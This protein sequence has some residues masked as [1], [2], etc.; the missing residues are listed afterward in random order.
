MYIYQQQAI[1]NAQRLTYARFMDGDGGIIF[2]RD[3]DFVSARTFE[4]EYK[5]LKAT[6]LFPVSSE[7]NP[8]ARNVI[9]RSYDKVAS[10]K[11]IG[12]HAKDLPRADVSGSETA[13]PIRHLGSS[14]GFSWLEAEAAAYAN[15]P[16]D[17]KRAMA[18]RR[19]VDEKI[20]DSAWN[21]H[22]PSGI[23]GLFSYTEIPTLTAPN[24]AGG[25]ATW[26]TKTADEILADVNAMF[27]AIKVDSLEKEAGD[28][29]ALPTAQY[30]L[31]HNTRIPDTSDTV[32]SYLLRSSQYLRGADSIVSAPELVGSGP[33]GTDE[34]FAY[35]KDPSK[36]ELV[37]PRFTIFLPSHQEGLEQVTPVI[38]TTSGLHYYKPLSARFMSGI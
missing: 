30:E 31:V 33:G 14:F 37:V 2:Q 6:T 1:A 26:I 27:T 16:L 4:V 19:A 23:K 21:G 13:Y 36:F 38:G 32:L 10:A 15:E 29:L 9:V 34:A 35:H 28:T 25:T 24:G 8:A 20:D 12:T 11:W 22:A 5:D 18:A 17:T 3:L 7:P